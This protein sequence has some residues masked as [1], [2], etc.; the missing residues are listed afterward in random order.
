MARLSTI[1]DEYRR[2]TGA[3]YGPSQCQCQC[4]MHV[5]R[6][7]AD[8]VENPHRDVVM[9]NLAADLIVIAA[10]SKAAVEPPGSHAFDGV[11]ASHTRL[12]VAS[13]I[14]ERGGPAVRPVSAELHLEC[15][16]EHR[17]REFSHYAPAIV[18]NAKTDKTRFLTT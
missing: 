13:K 6:P 14:Q 16:T 7:W 17:D 9:R 12:S 3:E 4:P 2:F 11:A 1:D 10:D 5:G 8:V 18:I 15:L